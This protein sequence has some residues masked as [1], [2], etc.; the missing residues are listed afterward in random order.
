MVM[1]M[2]GCTT[3]VPDLPDVL[4]ITW[5]TVRADHVGEA[6]TPTWNQL[7]ERAVVFSDARTPA[8]NTL[9]AHASIMTGEPPPAHGARDN[10]TWPVNESLTTVA[11]RFRDAGW[12]TGA[13]VS[14]STLDSRNG[15]GRGFAT[16]ND[17]I[18]PGAERVVAR[19]DGIDTVEAAIDWLMD[20]PPEQPV[21][22]WV[23]LFEPHRPW[24]ST[25]NPNQ[26][27]YQAAIRKTDK[28]TARLM[29]VMDARNRLES[30]IIA[31][32][33]DNGE[34]LGE[35]GEDSHGYLAY[36][37]TI[38]VPLLFWVGDSVSTAEA[39]SPVTI[40]GPASLLDVATTLTSAAG[41]K[42]VG[43][44]GIDLLSVVDSGFVPSRSLSVETVI[45]ALE[46]DAAPIFGVINP[47]RA[48]YDTPD[49]ERYHLDSDPKQLV[50]RYRA[51]DQNKAQAVFQKFPRRWPPTSDTTAPSAEEIEALES[52]G[53]TAKTTKN[54]AA[55][56]SDPKS[57]IALFNLLT[58]P[59]QVPAS[60][61][62]KLAD[63]ML[64]KHGMIPVLMLFKAD[65]YDSLARPVDARAVVRLASTAHPADRD[66]H[67]EYLTRTRKLEELRRL[68]D[69][70]ESEL[71]EKPGDTATRRDLALTYHRLQRFESAE[72]VYR[73]LLSEDPAQDDVRVDL[74]RMFASQERFDTALS[75]LAPALRRPDHSPGV[76]CL[77]G[78]VMSRG[79][80]RE[81]E[82]TPLLKHCEVH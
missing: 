31:I 11:E 72:A 37:S 28:A 79:L 42:P 44:S 2:G 35:H 13:F 41:L 8:P 55:S 1:I 56:I 23:H 81:K 9:P 6:W 50:N 18:R 3:T 74:A 49:P 47:T 5:D 53:Y 73:Q 63:A 70:I 22:M 77:A 7:A 19:R 66:L 20:K 76:D 38:R 27:D 60:E 61:L 68:A 34:G 33:S 71:V 10:G 46:F 36:E 54:T 29:D 58:N 15:I 21:F 12:T 57:K 82:S 39:T 67:S 78:Q 40:G 51:G 59:P 32:T 48:W 52:L 16:Y 64:E 65:I 4:L 24:D 80:G 45:P 14:A 62:L 69:A 26:T 25:Q 43:S 17:H 30:S 75:T